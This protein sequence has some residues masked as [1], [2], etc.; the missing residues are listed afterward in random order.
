MLFGETARKVCICSWEVA[1]Q[2]GGSGARVLG[3]SGASCLRHREQ[4]WRP[5]PAGRGQEASRAGRDGSWGLKGQE[6][7]LSF[8]SGG[9]ESGCCSV[10]G[11]A[12]R[13]PGQGA[14]VAL[15]LGSHL[16]GRREGQGRVGGVD[17]GRSRGSWLAWLRW[18]GQCPRLRRAGHWALHLVGHKAGETGEKEEAKTIPAGAQRLRG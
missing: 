15:S 13:T 17:G 7:D 9:T 6:K 12:L 14:G 2:G 5:G 10:E 18:S 11:G 16:G 1:S 4:R 8:H 3:C